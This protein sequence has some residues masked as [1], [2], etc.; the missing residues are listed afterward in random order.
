MRAIRIV[1]AWLTAA[2]TMTASVTGLWH[3]AYD[4]AEMGELGAVAIVAGFD[5]TAVIAGLRVVERPKDIGG[6]VMLVA[7]AALSAAAQIAASDPHL[8]WWRLLHGAP[9]VVSIW[10]LHGAVG[11]GQA[12]KAREEPPAKPKPKSSP[13]RSKRTE[14]APKP[15]PPAAASTAEP[16]Q[17]L[18][19][20]VVGRKKTPEQIA[21]EVDGWLAERSMDATKDNVKA[22][23]A[24]LNL[25][26]RGND[27]SLP[28]L[29]LV[30]ARRARAS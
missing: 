1:A 29:R 3:V 30:K 18:A 6:W 21:A 16:E 11:E 13:E 10:T 5:V 22:A 8:G 17:R 23:G 7:L 28:I 14:S 19:L 24:A 12:G 2:V 27:T 9:S 4:V 20:A 26:C 25:P 15:P